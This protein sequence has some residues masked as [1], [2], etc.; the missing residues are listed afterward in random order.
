MQTWNE[1][2]TWDVQ[3]FAGIFVLCYSLMV[4]FYTTI[5]TSKCIQWG[6]ENPTCPVFEWSK[7]WMVKTRWP[8]V[9]TI[10][11]I[12]FFV[13]QYIKRSRLI[14][15]WIP[16]IPKPD[17]YHPKFDLQNVRFLNVFFFERS[18]FRS[19]LYIMDEI[20]PRFKC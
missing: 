3:K 18:D 7:F 5:K 17:I 14:T 19:P 6:S 4:Y 12:R 20:H 9:Y 8:L 1:A 10:L 11:Y 15:I 2:L 16:D 13:W